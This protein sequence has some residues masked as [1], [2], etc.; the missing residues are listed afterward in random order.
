MDNTH[1]HLQKSVSVS[2]IA[3]LVLIFLGGLA[4]FYGV[5]ERLSVLESQFAEL[6]ARVVRVLEAQ[7]RV[8]Q[9]QD[10]SL[11]Q[12]RSEMRQDVRDIQSKLDRLIESL[13]K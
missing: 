10:A 11:T 5:A 9:S 4:A 2:Q 13:I 6:S 7:Q 1:W 12:F 3:A 8:D